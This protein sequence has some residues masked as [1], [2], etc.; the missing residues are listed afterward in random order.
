M[1]LT[2]PRRRTYSFDDKYRFTF[3]IHYIHFHSI[4][5]YDDDQNLLNMES[6][7]AL[8]GVNLEVQKFIDSWNKE[9]WEKLLD[10]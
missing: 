8:I 10:D 6:M 5:I 9:K 3:I 4:S 7:K 1:Q 2:D